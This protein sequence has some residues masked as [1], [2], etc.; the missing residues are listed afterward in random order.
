M[1][2]SRASSARAVGDR[3]RRY[4]WAMASAWAQVERSGAAGPEA[5]MSS[6][7]PSTSLRTML[8]TLAGA[9]AKANRP[10]LTADSRLRMVFIST[11]PAPQASSWPVMSCSSA[12]GSRGFSSRAL[13]PP[14]K[15]NRTVSPSRAL[16]ARSRAAWVA[17]NEF[18]SGTGCPAS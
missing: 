8:Y 15:R 18:S 7:S 3:R 9:Q 12:P 14:D 4:F 2:V 11:M 6:G 5:I 13:P 16:S 1:G 17:R 10:P